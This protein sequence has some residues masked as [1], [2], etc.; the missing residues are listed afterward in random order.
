MDRAIF[1]IA[2]LLL[3]LAGHSQCKL[4]RDGK[5]LVNSQNATLGK[6]YSD[7]VSIYNNDHRLL[8]K[9]GSNGKSVYCDHNALMFW[10]DKGKLMSPNN[11][12]I[13]TVSDAGRA[14]GVS[15]PTI[16]QVALW[17]FLCKN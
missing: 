15:Q 1:T 4:L 9:V 8:G 17:W 11:A 6:I 5:T 7:G 10:I 3:A 2:F 16:A 13:C 14:I 12:P